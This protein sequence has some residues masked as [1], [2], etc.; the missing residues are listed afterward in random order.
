MI[1]IRCR[2]KPNSRIA[3]KTARKGVKIFPATGALLVS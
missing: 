1:K 2:K 3:L